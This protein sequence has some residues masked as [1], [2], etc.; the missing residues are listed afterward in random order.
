MKNGLFKKILSLLLVLLFSFNSF[1]AIVS[2]NDGSAFVTKVEFES[3]KDNFATQI[4]NYE[5]SLD[6]KID[7]AIAAYLAGMRQVKVSSR[8][9][10]MGN[11]EDATCLDLTS[12]TYTK[13]KY[14]NPNLDGKLKIF[15]LPANVFETS[16]YYGVNTTTV[17]GTGK[18][19][20]RV[21]LKNLDKDNKLASW[22]GYSNETIEYYHLA[23][24]DNRTN[25]GAVSVN[26]TENYY[27][28]AG[29]WNQIT[30]ELNRDALL[31]TCTYRYESN[32]AG[33]NLKSQSYDIDYGT[34]IHQN[35]FIWKSKAQKDF[36]VYNT[37]LGFGNPAE[38]LG[39]TEGPPLKSF[40]DSFSN[41][42][43]GSS[44]WDSNSG[45]SHTA[46]TRIQRTLTGKWNSSHDND[47]VTTSPLV[48]PGMKIAKDYITNWNQIFQEKW[49]RGYT[50]DKSYLKMYAG[51]P[52]VTCNPGEKIR[53]DITFKKEKSTDPDKEYEIIA[54]IDPFDDGDP[55]ESKL[56]HIST[57]NKNW[58]KSAKITQKG[59]IYLD[60]LDKD[61]ITKK[62]QNIFI[63][64][65]LATDTDSYNGGGT[66]DLTNNV[67]VIS[68]PE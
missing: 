52:F 43:N 39:L 36:V 13:Y 63:K 28:S 44:G 57:D 60:L 38:D 46:S 40:G 18:K 17:G 32:S 27:V 5:K 35:A 11:I 64:W 65:R 22:Y 21:I 62:N 7:G 49:G 2:D 37:C 26:G 25:L 67:C 68:T 30:G 1:A 8:T 58:S 16:R 61:T 54:K 20:Q 56:L 50:S 6:G 41:A 45:I 29:S 19:G 34:V 66:I 47:K 3:L 31:G 33:R 12:E 14:G 55:D 53:Y 4:E 59:T 48:Y 15:G 51:F 10:I 9:I 23:S 24:T 42:S